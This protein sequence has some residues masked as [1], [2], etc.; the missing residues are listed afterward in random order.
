LIFSFPIVLFS[1]NREVLNNSDSLKTEEEI[2]I[3]IS[4]DLFEEHL[5][6]FIDT[7]NS[8]LKLSEYKILSYTGP[9]LYSD[10]LLNND[11]PLPKISKE[12]LDS[13]ET[14]IVSVRYSVKPF[15]NPIYWHAGNGKYDDSTGWI[16]NKSLI[17]HIV[18]EGQKYKIQKMGTGL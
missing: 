17:V 3:E 14:M 9:E 6:S 7:S 1:S 15:E 18:K 10:S 4:K 12:E 2:L 5:Q 13:G 11:I 16:N 8:A